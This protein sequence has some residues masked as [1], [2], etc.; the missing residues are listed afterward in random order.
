MQAKLGKKKLLALAL[1]KDHDHIHMCSA[2]YYANT[3]I[4]EH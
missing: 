1:Y 2:H 3:G 4:H